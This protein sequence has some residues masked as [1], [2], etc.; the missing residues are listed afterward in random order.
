MHQELLWPPPRVR[1]RGSC[2]PPKLARAQA[3]AGLRPTPHV[4]GRGCAGRWCSCAVELDLGLRGCMGELA[5]HEPEAGAVGAVRV[6]HRHGL[7]HG[8]GGGTGR[9]QGIW[10]A[11]VGVTVE[12]CHRL[13][14][15]RKYRTGMFIINGK[16]V[17]L[18]P[19]SS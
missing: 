8:G 9:L 3:E 15:T 17:I 18:Y 13:E 12:R 11:R 2:W 1:G 7:G 19:R 14:R 16:W 5:G 4:G 10:V 6:G